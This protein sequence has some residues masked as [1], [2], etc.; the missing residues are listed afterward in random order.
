MT[1]SYSTEEASINYYEFKIILLGDPAVGKTTLFNSFMDEEYNP[2]Y[3]TT[4]NVD[5][6]TNILRINQNT[7]AKLKIWDTCGQERYRSLTKIYLQG[8]HGV[9][10]LYDITEEN[11]FKNLDKWLSLINDCINKEEISI[12]LVG[13][14]IDM[15]VRKISTEKGQNFA[16]K[17]NLM[18]IETSSKEGTNVKD[19][20][21]MVTKDII[22]KSPILSPTQSVKAVKGRINNNLRCC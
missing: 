3:L 9:L 20:F 12:I 21:I 4:L 22:K 14:K 19:A 5:K 13:N 10:L 2:F 15:E 18:F 8:T 16:E 11:S 6:K 7:S 17:N 1:Y